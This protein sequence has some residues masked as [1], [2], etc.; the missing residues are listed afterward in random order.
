M[1]IY[2][3]LHVTQSKWHAPQW[4]LTIWLIFFTVD[5]PYIDIT[6]LAISITSNKSFWKQTR[7]KY[8][9]PVLYSVFY[10]YFFLINLHFLNNDKSYIIDFVTI[11]TIEYELP[12]DG[13]KSVFS[14]NIL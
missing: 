3:L 10:N 14:F 7:Y 8:G 6:N 1:Y 12:F 11:Y 2:Q 5:R 9:H 13:I 4:V